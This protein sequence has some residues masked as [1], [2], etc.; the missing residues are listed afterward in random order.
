M[1][2]MYQILYLYSLS[3]DKSG[4]R[5]SAQRWFQF[6]CKKYS[7]VRYVNPPPVSHLRVQY[8]Q[9]ARSM[10]LC[11]CLVTVL[12]KYHII[13]VRY[14]KFLRGRF[15]YTRNAEILYTQTTKM[16]PCSVQYSILSAGICCNIFLQGN[17][18][19]ARHKGI[20]C[21]SVSLLHYKSV[22]TG[23][24]RSIGGRGKK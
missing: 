24:T 22:Y 1:N 20:Y 12:L 3:L 9:N 6:V 21:Y 5:T 18:L 10:S 16:S 19:R 4:L 13:V 2:S 17:T 15:T 23:K 14:C 7:P 8:L 11:A